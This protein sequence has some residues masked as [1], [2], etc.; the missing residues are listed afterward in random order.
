MGSEMG[1][2]EELESRYESARQAYERARV[3]HLSSESSLVE[4]EE[5]REL[6]EA[7][8]GVEEELSAAFDRRIDARVVGVRPSAEIPRVIYEALPLVLQPELEALVAAEREV[9]RAE[10]RLEYARAHLRRLR[11]L[12]LETPGTP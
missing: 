5:L 8:E 11:G 3:V 6:R 4:G 7:M 10:Q 12:E 2:I 1:E 9:E